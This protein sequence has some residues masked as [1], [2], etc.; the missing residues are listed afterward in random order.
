M[1]RVE[2]A[3]HAHGDGLAA[4]D[5]WRPLRPRALRSWT[6]RISLVPSPWRKLERR[7]A[8]FLFLRLLAF[9]HQADVAVDDVFGRAFGF[10]A[11]VEQED[12]AVGELFDQPEIVG[13]EQDGD[14]ALAQFLEFADA[15]VGEDGVADGQGF[16]D[17][18]DF[19][20]DV[21]GG[22]E[23]QAHV[24]AAGVFLDGTLDE[25][26]DFG[27]GFDGGHGLFDLGAAEAEDLAVEEDVFA[28]GEFGVEAG[29][30]FEQG[31]DASAGDDAAAGGL[32]DAADDLQQGAFA[33][34][35]GADEAEGLA[36][37][38][39]EADVAERPEIGVARAAAG[40][41]LAQAVGGTAVETVQLRDVL[42]QDQI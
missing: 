39:G 17:D 26:A 22:G 20:V 6:R 42:N 13:D 10:D 41:Q 12:G 16:V 32:E 30:E 36:L 23:G 33:A 31:G 37:F 3:A 8:S 11:A 38:D 27:E 40:E 25:L 19:G 24:H 2:T 14:L 34:A 1:A 5:G 29:A 7:R 15:A 35:V 21:D 18:E 28:A 4:G 9:Q